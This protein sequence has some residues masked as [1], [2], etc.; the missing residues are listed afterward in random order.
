M[1]GKRLKIDGAR[2]R[3]EIRRVD[4]KGK[5]VAIMGWGHLVCPFYATAKRRCVPVLPRT[6]GG[7]E[8]RRMV[9]SR[10]R[11]VRVRSSGQPAESAAGT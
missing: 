4:D 10:I 8:L 11:G 7:C 2:R 3:N 5:A 1:E 6:C 9:P